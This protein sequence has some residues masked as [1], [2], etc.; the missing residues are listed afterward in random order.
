MSNRSLLTEQIRP[1]FINIVKTWEFDYLGF[2]YQPQ[3]WIEL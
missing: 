1:V 3:K 2:I